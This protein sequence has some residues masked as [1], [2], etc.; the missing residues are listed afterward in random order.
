MAEFLET[1]VITDL[2]DTDVIPC[3]D[4]SD[5]QR[6]KQLPFS[7][8]K[9][10]IGGQ[11]TD[12]T[13]SDSPPD[14]KTATQWRQPDPNGGPQIEWVWH[15]TLER[16]VSRE[17]YRSPIFGT[18]ADN[19][20][21]R[22]AINVP[23]AEICVDSIHSRCRFESRFN[24]DKTSIISIYFV[25]ANRQKYLYATVS[26]TTADVPDRYGEEFSSVVQIVQS[27]DAVYFELKPTSKSGAPDFEEVSININ[28]R[29]VYVPSSS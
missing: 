22:G 4:V 19:R 29:A 7:T 25:D 12:N 26:F 23:S 6:L 15:P 24:G 20:T 17:V 5:Q 11:E 27:A 9:R 18:N 28:F 21:Y 13:N 8:L 2:A 1:L 14:P 16:W 10:A 3:V